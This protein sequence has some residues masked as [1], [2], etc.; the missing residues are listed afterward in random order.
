MLWKPSR[1]SKRASK[2]FE[3]IGPKNVKNHE[4]SRPF[5]GL[6][7]TAPVSGEQAARTGCDCQDAPDESV[8]RDTKK[9]RENGV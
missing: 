1:G 9:E 6:L 3:G 8:G 5:N 7:A 2:T 4:L